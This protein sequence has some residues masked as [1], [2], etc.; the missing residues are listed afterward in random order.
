MI[1]DP[2]ELFKPIKNQ[3][4]KY[5]PTNIAIVTSRKIHEIEIK[6]FNLWQG[7]LP[8][9]LILLIK[10]GFQFEQSQYQQKPFI[11]KNLTYIVNKIHEFDGACGSPFIDNEDYLS[12]IKYF[13][14]KAFQ[15]FWMQINIGSWDIARQ[16]LLFCELTPNHLIQSQF[17]KTHNIAI[18]Q[19]IELCF[20]L[21]SWLAKDNRNQIFEPSTLFK[22]ISISEISVNRFCSTLSLKP[23]EVK[24]FIN[25]QSKLIHNPCFQLL[26]PSPLEQKPILSLDKEFLVYSRRLFERTI[27]SYLYDQVKSIGGSEASDLFAKTLEKYVK[28]A[29]KSAGLPFFDEVALK[30]VFPKSKVTDF[31]I[32]LPNCTVI[33][34]VK[35]IEMRPSVQVFPENKQLTNELKDNVIKATIQGFKLATNL[36]ENKK[37]ILNPVTF[38]PYLMILTYKDLFLGNGQQI[39]NEFLFSAVGSEFEKENINSSIIPPDHIIVLSL[40]EFDILMSIL[41]KSHNHLNKILFTMVKQNSKPKTEKFSFL[42]HLIPFLD[43]DPKLPY[44]DRTFNELT[45]RILS[46]FIK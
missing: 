9:Y 29:L 17:L 41:H 39:W 37:N 44:L 21:W 46:K 35:A 13:R 42:Q 8:W 40:F 25:T 2:Y 1:S 10:W 11:E 26:E 18:P 36:F 30:K 22:N 12:L 5:D 7:W 33:F 32:T 15:Q 27:N 34:E 16:Q 31:L 14:T 4:G 23:L 28:K 43:P 24:T 6:P 3:I 19:F 20:I 38:P 45:T